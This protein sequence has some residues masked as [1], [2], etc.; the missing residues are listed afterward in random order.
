MEA[1]GTAQFVR[2]KSFHGQTLAAGSSQR[3]PNAF[4]KP[5]IV[6]DACQVHVEIF[7]MLTATIFSQ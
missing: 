7:G 1:R 2:E 6:D 4:I 5:L 3:L